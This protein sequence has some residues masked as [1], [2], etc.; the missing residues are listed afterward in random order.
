MFVGS[1]NTGTGSLQ[2]EDVTAELIAPG[3]VPFDDVYFS[4]AYFDIDNDGDQDMYLIGRT[5]A[6][7]L[8]FCE[9]SFSAQ[10]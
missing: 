1:V 9:E 5:R 2:F 10:A 3:L 8:I 6:Y 7:L 4:H